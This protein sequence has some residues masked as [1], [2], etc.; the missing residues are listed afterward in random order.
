M[1]RR[2]NDILKIPSKKTNQSSLRS[3]GIGGGND[4]NVR[5]GGDSN[6]DETVDPPND[7]FNYA[8]LIVL[9]TYVS[10]HVRLLKKL[11]VHA[12]N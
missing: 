7:N 5:I 4:F 6:D 3:V 12:M 2:K 11:L 10:I 9:Y 1:S 8:L